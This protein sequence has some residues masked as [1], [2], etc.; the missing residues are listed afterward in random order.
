M[1][2]P[3]RLTVWIC[4]ITAVL[5]LLAGVLIL[6]APRLIQSEATQREIID[7]LS[8][9]VGGRVQFSGLHFSFFPQPHAVF[10]DAGLSMG[11]RLSVHIPSLTIYPKVWPFLVGRTAFARIEAQ[12]PRLTLVLPPPGETP[13]ARSLTPW[14]PE[15]LA[16]EVKALLGPALSG[17]EDMSSL[18]VH[19]AK[20]I[21]LREGASLLEVDH[22]H[23][24]GRSSSRGLA[25][26]LTAESSPCKHVSLKA[27]FDP[28]ACEAE[29]R[30]DLKG[31]AAGRL[32]PGLL[33]GLPIP[34][35]PDETALDLTFKIGTKGGLKADIRGELPL[36]RIVRKRHSARFKGARFKVTI[37]ASAGRLTVA[38][39]DLHLDEP[40]LDLLGTID[41]DSG[42]PRARLRLE[43]REVD[44]SSV[45]ETA[46]GLAH[47]VPVIRTIFDLLRGGNVPR[48]S[49]LSQGNTPADLGDLNH[50]LISGRI[51]NGR[52]HIRTTGMDLTEVSGDASVSKGMLTASRVRARLGKAHGSNGS[53]SVGLENGHDR[54]FHLDMTVQADL[55]EALPTIRRLITDPSVQRALD[56]IEQIQGTAEARLI[57]GETT[58]AMRVCVETS[59][60]DLRARYRP[61]PYP[62][63]AKGGRLLVDIGSVQ[64][65]RLEVGIG[66]SFLTALSGTL[67]W[68]GQSFLNLTARTGA[69]FMEEIH[70]WLLSLGN[71][72]ETLK[73][74]RVLRGTLLV[75]DLAMNG[76]LL[77]PTQW[78]FIGE[79]KV[80]DV[81]LLSSRLPGPLTLKEGSIRANGDAITLEGRG[82]GI[83]DARLN[84]SARM[85]GWPKGIHRL[86]AAMDGDMGEEAVRL[87]STAIHL[88][89]E[90]SLKAP[91]SVA[92]V[93]VG[94][95]RGGEM[96]FEGDLMISEGPC[97]SLKGGRTGSRLRIDRLHLTDETSNAV[98]Q[99]S[100]EKDA[101]RIGFSGNLT[102][103]SL[104][105]LL[106]QNR[107]LTGWIKGDLWGR[108]IPGSPIESLIEG[109]LEGGDYSLRPLNL[110]VL[111]ERFSLK[112]GQ[113]RMHFKSSL[114]ALDNRRIGLDT[115][116]DLSEQGI[117]YRANLS[118][119][120]LDLKQTAAA[121]EKVIRPD[122]GKRHIPW[123]V[124]IQ[125]TARIHLDCLA[126]DE[127]EWKPFVCHVA[128]QGPAIRIHIEDAALCGISTPGAIDLMDGKASIHVVP[129][130]RGME[131]TETIDCLTG[132]SLKISGTF[133]LQGDMA[134]QGTDEAFLRTL[135]GPISFVSK[136]GRIDRFGLLMNIFS[137]LNFTEIFRGRLPDLKSQGFAYDTL[138]VDGGFEGGE[139]RIKRALLDG[140]AMNIAATGHVNLL[141]DQI[142]LTVFAAPF[143][144]VDRIL[145]RLPILGYILD[146]TLAS[147][148]VR[149]TGDV[150]DPKVDYLP[151]SMIGLDL[152]GIMTRT[153]DAPLR[154]LTPMLPE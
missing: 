70:P 153:V 117:V 62:L 40:R 78:R 141:N 146:N 152:L 110:P 129:T 50:L 11:G 8:R 138:T 17:M 84:L 90:L 111:V 15:R 149:V 112:A 68:R 45:R 4:G 39:T 128:S 30:I 118:A 56:P 121:I 109:H 57:L 60:F 116:L 14:S 134:G 136:N 2:R 36:V 47:D 20:L 38:L 97:L 154:V 106:V 24:T 98:F 92:G 29:G 53:L 61:I 18:Q 114:L 52:V 101:L 89:H 77:D 88:P 46:M 104:D 44:V 79:A 71:T 99:L 86:D 25:V 75:K 1:K 126:Y 22:I 100:L 151:A 41:L 102:Q 7:L 83:L 35:G 33:P 73:Q 130:A 113:Q 26:E 119:E 87:A 5:I 107:I 143:K 32:P 139:F 115:D 34:I 3:K 31:V 69:I 108:I 142:D 147:I 137:L 91:I 144:M 6:L 74:V 10:F 123:E 133:D 67:E 95:E 12:S 131:L 82:L 23:L 63:Q 19:G 37:Q 124:P 80:N 55:G 103:S 28:R 9:K 54:P 65:D 148:P 135:R 145:R 105:S 122:Q 127:L 48:I 132:E 72:Q 59:A 93:H 125:G 58:A 43:A 64:A 42:A 16:A 96:S 51:S 81:N 140:S 49:V 85:S 150:K 27:Q 76:P 120:R 21:L 66:R 94:W 13:S